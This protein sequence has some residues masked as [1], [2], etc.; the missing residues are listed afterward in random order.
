VG[1]DCGLLVFTVICVCAGHAIPRSAPA[2]LATT[3]HALHRTLH[4]SWTKER[5]VLSSPLCVC[6]CVC[7]V[8][9]RKQEYVLPHASARARACVC[10]CRGCRPRHLCQ[11]FIL[12]RA[13]FLSAAGAG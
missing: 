12:A 2:V 10:V 5:V 1:R 8:G 7:G 9:G 3:L 6:V 4:S 13:V 11:R